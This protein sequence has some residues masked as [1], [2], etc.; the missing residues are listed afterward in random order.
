MSQNDTSVTKDGTKGKEEAGASRHTKKND[1]SK[2]EL[3]RA[4]VELDNNVCCHGNKRQ[5]EYCTKTTECIADCVRREHNKT[6][7]S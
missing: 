4:V 5:T 3:Q 1:N 2:V 7:G 6:L